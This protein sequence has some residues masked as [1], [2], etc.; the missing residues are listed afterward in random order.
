MDSFS[1]HADHDEILKFLTPLD[2]KRI[3][4]VFLVHGEDTSQKALQ[5]A[6]LVEGFRDVYIPGYGE[7]VALDS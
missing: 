6:M 4:K 1:A 5:Q 3:K 2:R 7:M